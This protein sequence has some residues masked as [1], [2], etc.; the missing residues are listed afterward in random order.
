MSND[1]MV[2]FIRTM[3]TE[4]NRQLAEKFREMP[5]GYTLCSHEN[6]EL[7]EK[8]CKFFIEAHVL[9][10]G[11]MCEAPV[12]KTQYGPKEELNGS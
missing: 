1:G 2:N 5:V 4:Y 9:A 11:E 3:T 12:I 7:D 6:L 10:L 8:T